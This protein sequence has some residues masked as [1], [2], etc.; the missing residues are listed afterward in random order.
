ENTLVEKH[1]DILKADSKEQK[2]FL[3]VATTY[4]SLIKNRNQLPSLSSWK[5]EPSIIEVESIIEQQKSGF[6]SKRRAITRWNELSHLPIQ[7]AS[8]AYTELKNRI[9]LEQKLSKTE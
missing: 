7:K 5:L 9:D 3:K 1:S 4:Q 6:W 8:L 2:Q